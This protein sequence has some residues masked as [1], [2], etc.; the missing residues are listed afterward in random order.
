VPDEWVDNPEADGPLPAE[1][2]AAYRNAFL[3]GID[4]V[5][6]QEPALRAFCDVV[7]EAGLGVEEPLLFLDA[8][9]MDLERDRYPTYESLRGYMRGSASA[10]GL[11]MCGLIGA[12]PNDPEVREPAM[13]LGE[14]MQLTNFLRDV[15]EDLDRGRIYLP[16]EDL[17][18]FDLTEADLLARRSDERTIR[19]VRFEIARARALYALADRGIPRL[20]RHARKPVLLARC[21]YARIL[22]RIEDQGC[23]VFAGRARTSGAE[24]LSVL[25]RVLLGRRV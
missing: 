7:R 18:S 19:L 1:R 24:K 13:A 16:L 21:L 2:L 9:A 25:A 3:R 10:V 14:A 23:D 5:R 20:P 15:A 17:A 11:M 6:P 8:M 12:D 22:D 4:G